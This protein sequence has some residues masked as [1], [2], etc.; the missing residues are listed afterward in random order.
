MSTPLD[1]LWPPAHAQMRGT[2]KKHRRRTRALDTYSDCIGVA[3]I[4]NPSAGASC[5]NEE[6]CCKSRLDLTSATTGLVSG[7]LFLD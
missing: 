3:C 1:R 5:G 4:T 7:A 2:V 6:I